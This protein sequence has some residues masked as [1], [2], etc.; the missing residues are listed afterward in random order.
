M[1]PEKQNPPG[2]SPPCDGPRAVKGAL[3]IQTL[4]MANVAKKNKKNKW[5]KL[6]KYAIVTA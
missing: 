6:N 1:L 2:L 3:C 5:M 4:K